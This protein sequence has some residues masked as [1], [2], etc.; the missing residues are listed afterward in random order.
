MPNEPL[1]HG[2]L[3]FFFFFSPYLFIQKIQLENIPNKTKTHQEPTEP[4]TNQPQTSPTPGNTPPRRTGTA[5]RHLQWH[6]A[7]PA[8]P[9]QVR[10]RPG[11]ARPVT[12]AEPAHRRRRRRRPQ[13]QPPRPEGSRNKRRRPSSISESALCRAAPVNT[14]AGPATHPTPPPVDAPAA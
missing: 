14:Q 5:P 2:E 12:A 6:Q 8:K 11:P 9:D 7:Q 10:Y 13:G 4:K 3:G 1:A